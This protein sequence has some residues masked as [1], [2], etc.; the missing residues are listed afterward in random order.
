[1]H[2]NLVTVLAALSMGA[3][4]V[5]AC[6]DYGYATFYNDHAC[7]DGGGQAVALNNGGCLANQIGRNSVYVQAPCRTTGNGGPSMV[8][9]PGTN[10]NCQNDC[11]AVPTR[12]GCWDLGG[13]KGASS[14]R[15]IEQNCGS[16]N[17]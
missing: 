11:A 17:C 14:F 12:Q 9:S 3:G 6:V 4:T 2:F 8:W 13:H 1:M 15:F 10:C 7:R 16:N 5:T